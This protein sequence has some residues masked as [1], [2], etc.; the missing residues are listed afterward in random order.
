[1]WHNVITNEDHNGRDSGIL[2]EISSFQNGVSSKDPIG[3]ALKK[4]L[5]LF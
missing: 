1:M 5:L 4:L 2:G 3:E